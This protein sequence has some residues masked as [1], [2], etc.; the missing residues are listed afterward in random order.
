MT[1]I[2]HPKVGHYSGENDHI[3]TLQ[4]SR[5]IVQK[6]DAATTL[7]KKAAGL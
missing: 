1:H 4:C 5:P 3:S 6:L 7:A 2:L